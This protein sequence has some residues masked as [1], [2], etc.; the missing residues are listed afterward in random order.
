MS[1]WFTPA[2][3]RKVFLGLLGLGAL[4]AVNSLTM[5]FA[6]SDSSIFSITVP[7]LLKNLLLGF[8]PAAL[9]YIL[10]RFAKSKYGEEPEE[11]KKPEPENEN[12]IPDEK[13]I[14]ICN[15]GVW[16]FYILAMAGVLIFYKLKS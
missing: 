9:S 11:E 14:K 15:R 5:F 7:E 8:S 13:L 1:G 2:N 4:R 6:L 16:V 3:L 10:Y 12:L